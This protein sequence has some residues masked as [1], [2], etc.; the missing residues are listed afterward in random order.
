MKTKLYRLI[1]LL[2]II[3][4]CYIKNNKPFTRDCSSMDCTWANDTIVS[5][6][7]PYSEYVIAFYNNPYQF[8]STNI[9]RLSLSNETIFIG[10]FAK[11]INIRLPNRFIDDYFVPVLEIKDGNNVHQWGDGKNFP[12]FFGHCQNDT[13]RLFKTRNIIKIFFLPDLPPPDNILFEP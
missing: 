9:L 6:T 2:F 8:D 4:N 10:R 12:I 3:N 13:H 11:N 7:F 1:F 5:D